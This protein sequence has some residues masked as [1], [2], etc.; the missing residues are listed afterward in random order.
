MQDA[1][2]HPEKYERAPHTRAFTAQQQAKIDALSHEHSFMWRD[3]EQ[4]Y[5]CE[6]GEYAINQD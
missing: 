1:R 6:C 5:R 3:H 4:G 2:N